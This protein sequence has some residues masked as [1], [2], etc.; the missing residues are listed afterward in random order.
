MGK[1][2]KT[3][4]L[5]LQEY[6][7]NPLVLKQAGSRAVPA[8]HAPCVLSEVLV[9]GAGD[10]AASAFVWALACGVHKERPLILWAQDRLVSLE[11]GQPYLP[12]LHGDA[13][14]DQRFVLI[15]AKASQDM[16]WAMEEALLSGAAACVIGEIWGHPKCLTFTATKRLQ[17]A[18][19]IGKTP[20]LLLR[21]GR[22][23]VSSGAYERWHAA[24]QPS[25]AH[26]DDPAAPGPPRWSLDLFKARTRQPSDWKVEYDQ[27]AHRLHLAA[28]LGDGSVR[29]TA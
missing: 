13:A 1:A 24:S 26:P 15:R 14:L 20:C 18:A 21:Y 29:K 6:H 23:R 27:P 25:A 3:I 5:H 17:R 16:L 12:G 9:D 7:S 11:A 2:Q 22:E 10:G 4:P 8:L 28:P 19:Q